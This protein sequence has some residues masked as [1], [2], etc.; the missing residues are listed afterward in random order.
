MLPEAMGL[1]KPAGALSTSGAEAKRYF[2]YLRRMGY[3]TN[4][5]DIAS[6]RVP[7]VMLGDQAA[8]D[9]VAASASSCIP[10][11]MDTLLL[12][13][14]LGVPMV[15]HDRP[16][17]WNEEALAYMTQQ[18][19]EEIEY[20][21]FLFPGYKFSM[22]KLAK[23]VEY[24]SGVAKV[25]REF[26]KLRRLKPTPISGLDAISSGDEMMRGMHSPED[27][28]WASLYLEE[29]QEKAAKGLGAVNRHGV[30][31]KARIGWC[32]SNPFF[33]DPFTFL[34]KL[35]VS[36]PVWIVDSFDEQT[37]GRS[38]TTGDEEFGRK[39]NPLEEVARNMGTAGWGDRG[40]HYVNSIINTCR[41][42][43]LDGII[44]FKQTGCQ[45]ATPFGTL[46]A[47]RGER[48]LGI[49]TLQLEG[50]QLDQTGFD[51]RAI[52]SVLV[53]FTN[54][55]FARKQLPPLSQKDLER[56]GY[57]DGSYKGWR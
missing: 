14:L 11:M 1:C 23:Q 10:P 51:E 54:I 35:G 31:E 28:E 13:H 47:E 34:E 9:Y 50:R 57:T 42:L 33:Y 25:R 56:A 53:D 21:E 46:V 41:D 38:P 16:P 44:Y 4:S 55:M 19:E 40:H 36:M 52:L 8:S 20:L 39:L 29:F 15:A 30:E 27:L 5:C 6:V 12:A 17:Q 45:V 26:W 18:M 2:D 7:A 48:E 3:N 49:P 37:S 22:D 43:E 24:Q 32:V